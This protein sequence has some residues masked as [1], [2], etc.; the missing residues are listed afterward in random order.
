MFVPFPDYDRRASKLL[1]KLPWNA[2]V[3]I[4]AE[5]KLYGSK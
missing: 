1:E 4:D 2:G 3:S 5:P